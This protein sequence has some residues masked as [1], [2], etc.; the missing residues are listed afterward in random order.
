VLLLAD[1]KLYRKSRAVLQICRRL[2]GVWPVL[3]YLLAWVPTALA[4]RAYDYI[5]NH[6]Y[7]W[8]GQKDM[9]W[10]PTPALAARFIDVPH[11]STVSKSAP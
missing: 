10:I 2:D 6:R 11:D 4:D 7:R 3:Y 8:F 1:G 9:C 5:G